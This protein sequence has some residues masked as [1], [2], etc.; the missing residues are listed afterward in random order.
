[1]VA[2]S[3]GHRVW[4]YQLPID[5]ENFTVDMPRDATILSVQVQHSSPCL[6]ADVWP[7]SSVI[8]RQFCWVGTGK[9]VPSGA[10]VHRG[11]VI[12]FDDALVLHLYEYL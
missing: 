12:L 2:I 10:V 11:T 6:W 8:G 1:M 7:E 3:T 9:S 5:C 4:K